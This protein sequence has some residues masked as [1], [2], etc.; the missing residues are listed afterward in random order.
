MERLMETSTTNWHDDYVT[1]NGIKIHYYRTGGDKPKVVFNHGVT[2]DG[3]CWTH[4]AKA[5]EA[6]YDVIMLDARGHGRSGSGHGDYSPEARAADLAGLI[7]AL[8]LERPVVGGHSLGA[9]TTAHLAAHY[10]ELTRGIFLEDP[11]I[12]M[13]GE[14]FGDG[15]QIKSVDDVGKMMAKYMRPFKLL[16][17]FIAVPLA[18]KAFPTYPDDELIPWVD[19][20]KRMSGDIFNSFASMGIGVGDPL[21]VFRQITVPVLLIIGDKD[22]G[23]IVSQATAQEVAKVNDRVKVVHLA[24]ANHDIRRCRFDGY[25]VALQAFIAEMY[26][27]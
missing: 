19:S 6:Q 20:K 11:P 13:P 17:K 3:L 15:V 22:K 2:D 8:K 1:A 9:D 7:Q 27:A 16:P 18:R 23:S 10:P 25:I 4:V 24:G 5:L 14:P 26:A 12:I 21:P